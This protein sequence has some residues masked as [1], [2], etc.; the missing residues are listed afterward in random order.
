MRHSDHDKV[1]A[2]H[3]LRCGVPGLLALL[4]VSV[5]PL[6]AQNAT[7]QELTKKVQL[8]TDAM[9]KAQAQL[10]QSQRQ[11][12]DL[13]LQLAAV[14][15][16]IGA[17]SG[18]PDPAGNAAELNA[19]VESLK[20]NE[21]VLQSEV[22]TH[23]QSKVESASKYPVKLS[24]LI[25]LNGFVNTGQV[26][27]PAEPGIALAG[28]GSTG[29]T[30]RQTV[31]GV[32]ARGPHVFGAASLADFR[33]DFFGSAGGTGS[34]G[35]IG[36]MRLR[37]AHAALQWANTAV[38]FSLDRPLI[39]PWQPTSLT[40]IA[41]PALAWSGNLWSWNPQVG[42]RRDQSL[43]GDT[44][45]RLESALIDVSDPPYAVATG[46]ASSGEL[47]RWPGVETRI[48]IVRGDEARGF[49]LGT[50]G[51]FAKHRTV[52]GSHY[53]SWAGTLDYRQPLPGG[54]ELSGN[55]YRGLALGG[56]GGGAFKDYGVRADP[57][58]PRVYYI[59]A[60]DDVG[61]WAQLKER[62]GERLEF[63]EAVGVDDIP[64]R[65]LRRNPAAE[66]GIYQNLARTQTVMGNAI[67]SP[68]A[69]LQFSLDYR[70][71]TSFSANGPAASSNIIGVAAGYKF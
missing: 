65:Q 35:T 33:V 45:I 6:H 41:S 7:Q 51:Y 10:E 37:T 29:A 36:L 64:G 32:D 38:Y 66:S 53:D 25:L 47:S 22:A 55:F 59:P 30:M 67:F 40:S 27:V 19:Q 43:V 39:N 44:R 34:Y 16:E 69:W 71:L 13:R 21:A 63:N 52:Y 26:D 1:F 9:E 3:V 48:A 31:L 46:T 8:L 70:Y 54:L 50:G 58:N 15:R 2:A 68:S 49:Q 5:V 18:D 17:G 57:D 61:G 60:F 28:P 11:L 12:D 56:L 24:G 20:E 62:A 4:L 23:D 14:R 42:V